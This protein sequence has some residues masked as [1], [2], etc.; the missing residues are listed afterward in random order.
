MLIRL[1]GKLAPRYLHGLFHLSI[2]TDIFWL[3]VQNGADLTWVNNKGQ[4]LAHLLMHNR[5]ANEV[6]LDT[7]F[8]IGLDPAATDVDGRTLMHHGASW[9]VHQEACRVF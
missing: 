1:G 2:Q 7:L 4:N 9:R 8:G 5:G 3:L 6:I